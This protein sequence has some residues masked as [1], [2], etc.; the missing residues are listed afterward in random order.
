MEHHKFIRQ[1]FTLAQKAVKRGNQPFGA[2]LVHDGKVLFSAENTVNTNNDCT[3]H[4]EL[5]LVSRASRQYSPEILTTSILYSSTE[6]CAMCA[7]A[8]YWSGIPV[9][10]Y[11]CSAKALREISGRN[12]LM[13]CRA[14]FANGVRH[15]E[16]IGPILEAEGIKILQG[17]WNA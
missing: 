9:V 14:V 7:G 11:G 4:A 17:F 15:T 16:I 3:C 8:I 10:A 1:C 6:P 13:N 5:N 2:L 12:L